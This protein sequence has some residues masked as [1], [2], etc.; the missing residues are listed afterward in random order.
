MQ[1]HI[2]V[3]EHLLLWLGLGAVG[4]VVAVIAVLFFRTPPATPPVPISPPA[5]LPLSLEYGPTFNPGTGTVYDGKG[6]G[7]PIRLAPPLSLEYGPTFNPG[8]GT[9]Y[10]GKGYGGVIA[11]EVNP[12]VPISGT[13]SAYDGQ[14][15]GSPAPAPAKNPNVPISGTGSAYDGQ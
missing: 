2:H 3:P 9:V 14:H 12:N 8:T 6:Y 4:I 15:Y 1:P 13:G 11:P 10:D 7:T 5:A